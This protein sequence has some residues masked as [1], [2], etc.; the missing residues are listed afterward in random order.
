MSA[1][2]RAEP[3]GDGGHAGHHSTLRGIVLKIVSVAVFV[4][5]QTC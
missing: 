5:M 3:Q 4:G 1:E 2:A